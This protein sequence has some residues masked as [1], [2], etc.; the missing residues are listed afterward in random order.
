MSDQNSLNP[1]ESTTARD[2]FVTDL[3]SLSSHAQELLHVTNTVSGEGIAAAREQLQVSVHAAGET[4]K[5][6]QAE[7]MDRGRKVARQADSYVHENPWQS[8]AIGMAAGMA[9]GLATSSMTRGMGARA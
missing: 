9:I 7:A 6:I 8:I 3:Q 4:L 5:R 1:N 2:R